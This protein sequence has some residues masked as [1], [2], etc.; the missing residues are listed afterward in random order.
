V[1]ILN[2]KDIITEQAEPPLTPIEGLVTRLRM[3][4]DLKNLN[5]P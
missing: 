1:I 4:M 2:E 3:D 5:E